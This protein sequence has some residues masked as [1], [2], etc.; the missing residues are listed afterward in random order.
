MDDSIVVTPQG[1]RVVSRQ[2]NRLELEI[3]EAEFTVKV[4][5]FDENRDLRVKIRPLEERQ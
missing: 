5:G 1:A 4:T 2:D 3:E